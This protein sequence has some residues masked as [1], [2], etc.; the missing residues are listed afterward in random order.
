MDFKQNDII[1]ISSRN[2]KCENDND[3]DIIEMNNIPLLT[4]RIAQKPKSK[5]IIYKIYLYLLKKTYFDK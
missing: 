5:Q 1:N 4:E 2:T 3:A